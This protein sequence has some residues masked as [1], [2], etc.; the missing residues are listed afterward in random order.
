MFS[1]IFEGVSVFSR[2]YEG[3][4]CFCHRSERSERRGLYS[5][6]QEIGK[7]LRFFRFFVVTPSLHAGK[8]LPAD[9]FKQ[10]AGLTMAG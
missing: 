8:K 10:N 9:G 4:P 1:R 5:F 3:G 7:L 2:I 6:T